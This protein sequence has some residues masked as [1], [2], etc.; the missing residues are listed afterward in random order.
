MAYE[1]YMYFLF[2]MVSG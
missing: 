1:L 2:V